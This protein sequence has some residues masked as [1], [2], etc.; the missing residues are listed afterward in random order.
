MRTLVSL[1]F[2]VAVVWFT[3]SVKLGARTLAEHVDRIGQTPAA[4]DLIDGTRS[5]V[6]PALDEAKRRILGEYVEAPTYVD[7]GHDPATEHDPASPASTDATHVST[8]ENV[9]LPGR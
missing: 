8:A 3:F 2:L 4:R 9:K 7:G 6:N 1:A 5:T